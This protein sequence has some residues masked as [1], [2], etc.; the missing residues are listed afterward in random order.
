[1][2]AGRFSSAENTGRMLSASRDMKDLVADGEGA[3]S[4]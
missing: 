3:L 2:K 4:Y 1:M